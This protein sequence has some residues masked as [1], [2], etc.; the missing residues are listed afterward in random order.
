MPTPL[1]LLYDIL[2][3]LLVVAALALLYLWQRTI[4]NRRELAKLA[5]EVQ[6]L[7]HEFQR[8]KGAALT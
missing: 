4:A 3:S 5:A 7:R 1:L 2:G 8:R 6:E